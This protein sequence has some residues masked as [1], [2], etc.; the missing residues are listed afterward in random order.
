[1]FDCLQKASFVHFEAHSKEQPA[2]QCIIRQMLLDTHDHEHKGKLKKLEL[3]QTLMDLALHTILHDDPLEIQEV[4]TTRIEPISL[5]IN[6]RYMQYYT[7]SK[8]LLLVKL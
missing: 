2:S 4:S 6:K 8:F 7:Q 5:P 3:E 1:M